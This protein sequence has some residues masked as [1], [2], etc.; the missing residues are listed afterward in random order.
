VY[1]SGKGN[2]NTHGDIIIWQQ[3]VTWVVGN[4]KK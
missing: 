4:K 3:G 2:A 1:K